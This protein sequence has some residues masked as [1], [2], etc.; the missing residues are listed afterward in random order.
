MSNNKKKVSVIIPCRNEVNS[1]EQ[2]LKKIYDFDPPKGGFEVIVVD[3]MSDDGTPELLGKLKKERYPDLVILDNP[4]RTAPIAMNL[5]IQRAQG[6]YVMRTDPRCIH[7]KSYLVDLLKLSEE[8]KADNVGGVLIPAGNNY[9]QKS[10]ATAYK[11]SIAMG[12]A[13]RDRGDFIGETD[14]V[15]GGFFRR[16]RLV[17]VG[18]YDEGM[19]RNQDDELSFRLRKLGGKIIQSGKIKI[20]YFPRNKLSQ[21][22]KQFFQYGYW[23]ITVLKKHP[24]QISF[25]HF[26][27]AILVGGFFILAFLSFFSDKAFMGLLLYGISYLVVLSLESL[28]LTYNNELKLWPAVIMSIGSMHIGFGLGFILALICQFINIEPKWTASLSR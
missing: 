1:I 3:G 12:G 28:R 5:G 10:I 27:P 21:L 6:E 16:K 25:R 4:K 8:T 2:C 22:F 15:Y 18:M 24:K 26:A 13:L 23:K 7:P 11:S 19:V 20:R 14:A 9:I 17:E